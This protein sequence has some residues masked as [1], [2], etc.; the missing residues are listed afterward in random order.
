MEIFK[1]VTLSLSGLLLT[2]V[3]LMRLLNPKQA[4][5]KNS[6]IQL[7]D[8]VNLLNEMRGVSAVQLM[9]GIIT[10]LGTIIAP[11]TVVAFALAS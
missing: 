2:L 11:L 10:L 7:A 6:G 9:G 1:I 5:A 4:Y 3:G 8:D